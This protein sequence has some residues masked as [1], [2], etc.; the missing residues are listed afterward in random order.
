MRH[1]ALPHLRAA[2]LPSQGSVTK[3]MRSWHSWTALGLRLCPHQAGIRPCLP[4]MPT[5][6]AARSWHSTSPWPSLPATNWTAP[7][8]PPALHG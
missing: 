7:L 5:C 8:P 4:A 6:Q 2:S 1:K 3:G